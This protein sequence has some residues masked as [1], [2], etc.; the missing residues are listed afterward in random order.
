MARFDIDIPIAVTLLVLARHGL[1]G[2][3][4]VFAIE[5]CELRGRQISRP[6]AFLSEYQGG[7]G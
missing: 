1:E 6:N 2:R 5:V 7:G 4:R 3:G